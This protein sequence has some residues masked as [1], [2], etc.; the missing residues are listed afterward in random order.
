VEVRITEDGEILL[1]GVGSFK[2]I[3]S[4]LRDHEEF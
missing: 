4:D 1:G 2:V 3:T